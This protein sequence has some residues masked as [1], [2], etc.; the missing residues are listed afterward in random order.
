[1]VQIV[2]TFTSLSPAYLFKYLLLL[3]LL[4]YLEA[5]AVP[6]LLVDLAREFSM[7]QFTTGLMGGIVYLMLSFGGPLA[8]VL[9]KNHSAKPI[10]LCSLFLNNLCTLFFGLTPE[11]NV[12]LLV[13]TRGLIGFTQVVVCVYSPLWVDS[14]APPS[15]RARYM[16]YLQAR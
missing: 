3:N 7:D 4:L 13:A 9:L 8:G 10:I 14:H 16:S 11:G 2:Q 6:A 1:M 15:M 12:W 5:G